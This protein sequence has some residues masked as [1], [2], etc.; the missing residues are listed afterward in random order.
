MNTQVSQT[1]IAIAIVSFYVL[2]FALNALLASLRNLLLDVTPHEQLNAGNA[3]H[4]RMTHGG[5]ILGYG[6]GLYCEV[7]VPGFRLTATRL[8]STCQTPSPS[9]ARR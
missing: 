5:N 8:S 4:G 2:D 9:L 7:P 6:F 3:W 1:A